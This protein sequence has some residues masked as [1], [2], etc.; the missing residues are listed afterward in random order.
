MAKDTIT[1]FR[2]YYDFDKEFAFINDMNKKGYKLVYIKAGCLFT[3]VKS[4]P[5]EYKTIMYAEDK[6][7]ISEV[8]ML[9]AQCGYENIPHTMD[10]IGDV[11]YLTGRKSEIA[12]DFV[13]ENQ[14][15]A[16]IY[17][18]LVKKFKI[19]NIL[20]WILTFLLF[21]DTAII[22]Y[23]LYSTIDEYG[24]DVGLCIIG[25]FTF[26]FFVMC[27]VSLI[28]CMSINSKYKIRVLQYESESL[29]YE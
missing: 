8:C 3:F 15:K 4:E 13:N 22:N 29:I 7:R 27:L 18:K 14:A 28:K 1:K 11:L 10:G 20:F 16:R 12:E 25:A 24:F 17:K 6:E 5:D 19:F 23:T 21:F 2:A 26:V 9:A